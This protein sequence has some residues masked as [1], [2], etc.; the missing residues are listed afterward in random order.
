MSRRLLQAATALVGIA[1]VGLGTVQL[2]R[3][4][5]SPMYA[6]LALPADPTLDSNLRFFGGLGLGL[7]IVLLLLVPRIERHGPVF[8]AV[9]LCTLVGGVGRLLSWAL[10]G[11]PPIHLAAF[12]WIEVLGA[13]LFVLWQ[14]SVG[15]RPGSPGTPPPPC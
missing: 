11:A 10:V 15:R 6:H 4:A 1:T 12:T 5:A 2:L 14:R 13:P 7:G 3:G 8:A 9:W